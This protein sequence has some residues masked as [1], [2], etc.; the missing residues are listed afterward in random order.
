MQRS[1]DAVLGVVAAIVMLPILLGLAILFSPVWVPTAIYK[2]FTNRKLIRHFH[3][4]YVSQGKFVIFVYSDSPNWKEYLE[5]NILPRL[6][7]H[8]VILNYSRR[9]EWKVDP[10]LPVKVFHLRKGSREYNP[11]ALLFAPDGK[12]TSIRFLQAFRKF[13][14]GKESLLRSKEK[15]LFHEVGRLKQLYEL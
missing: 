2:R 5:A 3:E 14:H 8:V 9:A 6:E 7:R 4:T 12:I 1:K 10:S 13:K 15:E 11:M